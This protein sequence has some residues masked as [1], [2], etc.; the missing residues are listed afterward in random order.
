MRRLS[1]YDGPREYLKGEHGIEL[2]AQAWRKLGDLLNEQAEINVQVR[3]LTAAITAVW[4][5][6]PGEPA[7]A[8]ELRNKSEYE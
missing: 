5:R 3:E 6:V 8:A 7:L 1:Q 4:P 2:Y